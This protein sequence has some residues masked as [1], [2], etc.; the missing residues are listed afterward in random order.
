MNKDTVILFLNSVKNDDLIFIYVFDEPYRFIKQN[1]NY[2]VNSADNT[3][4]IQTRHN[5]R[6]FLIH[7]DNIKS[8]S[9]ISKR[10]YNHKR[11]MGAKV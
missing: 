8:M 4:A 9:T 2:D 1:I 7:I 10:E 5:D 6:V 11:E 3:L